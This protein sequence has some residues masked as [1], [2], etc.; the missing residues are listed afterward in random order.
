MVKFAIST[1]LKPAVREVTEENMAVVNFPKAVVC[2][3]RLVF[4]SE[5]RKNTAPAAIKITVV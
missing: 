5:K 3:R 4:C 1:V 2:G